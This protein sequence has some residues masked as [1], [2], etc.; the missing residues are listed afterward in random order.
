MNSNCTQKNNTTWDTKRT[1]QANLTETLPKISSSG[2][3]DSN[4]FN[5]FKTDSHSEIKLGRA[6]EPIL[7]QTGCEQPDAPGKKNLNNAYK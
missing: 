1:K 7:L 6:R 5:F 4:F 3:K 2:Q